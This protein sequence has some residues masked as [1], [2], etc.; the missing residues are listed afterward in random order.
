[1]PRGLVFFDDDDGR[2]R[3]TTTT[4]RMGSGTPSIQPYRAPR[5]FSPMPPLSFWRRARW[6]FP[7]LIASAPATGIAHLSSRRMRSSTSARASKRCLIRTAQ[8]RCF[9]KLTSRSS[10]LMARQ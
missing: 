4:T 2:R 9:R 8:M 6:S 5:P 3:R 7:R 10:A 1:M